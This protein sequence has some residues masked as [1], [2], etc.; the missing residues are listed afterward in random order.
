M[1]AVRR[2]AGCEIEASPQPRGARR[3]IHAGQ[4]QSGYAAEPGCGGGLGLGG[5]RGFR[6]SAAG[7]AAAARAAG[8]GYG[9]RRGAPRGSR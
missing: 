2:S 1:R 6:G 9:R 5:L 8:R 7:R 4:W 3:P